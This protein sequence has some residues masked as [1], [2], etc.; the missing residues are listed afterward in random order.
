[1][2]ET[3]GI[4][5]TTKNRKDELVKCLN[6]CISLNGLDEILVFDDGSNDGT[7]EL[8]KNNFPTV[9]LY[10]TETSLGLINA[11]TECS[12]LFGSEII[13][14]IDDDCVFDDIDT[15]IEIKNYFCSSRIAAVTIPVIDVL[16]SSNI[17]QKGIGE[18]GDIYI[19]S[20]YRGCGHAIRKSIFLELGGY[21]KDLVRQEEETDIAMR[22][23]NMNYLIRVGNCKKPILHF[24]STIR[25]EKVITFYQA[26]NKIILAYAHTPIYLLIPSLLRIFF[27]ML[28]YAIEKKELVS[29]ANGLWDAFKL[30]FTGKIQRTPQNFQVFV[31]YKKL[32][33]NGYQK[34][35][36]L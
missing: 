16:K 31:F 20:Q 19:T 18:I 30:I 22:I 15:L 23:Y 1:M 35:D 32:R 27:N 36:R 33:L 25:N 8:V 14:S 5:I 3:I 21:R 7:Y 4:V 6:S 34:L 9:K 28:A 26:R 12:K 17:T 2:N 24:H 10:R 13:V 11:R 29:G